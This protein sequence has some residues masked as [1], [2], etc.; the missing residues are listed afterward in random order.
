MS[1]PPNSTLGLD[2]SAQIRERLIRDLKD[3]NFLLYY[4]TVVPVTPSAKLPALREILV[5]FKEEEQ[6][7]IAPGTF[8]PVLEEHRLMP[9]LDRKWPRCSDGSAPSR[10]RAPP[11]SRVAA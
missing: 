6:Y 8:L 5:R 11:T 4:Q 9:L 2:V 10:H 7:L 1:E 3:N